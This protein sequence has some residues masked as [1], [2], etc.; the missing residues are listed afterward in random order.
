M[1][2]CD[3]DGN[4]V[5][6]YVCGQ[7]PRVVIIVVVVEYEY[8]VLCIRCEIQGCVYVCG[9]VVINT[10]VVISLCRCHGVVLPA[11]YV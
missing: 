11:E 9:L 3:K 7:H 5:W 2:G 6:R 4:G 10:V 1:E 8:T